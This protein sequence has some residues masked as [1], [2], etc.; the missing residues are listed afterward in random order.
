MSIDNR[1]RPPVPNEGRIEH[2]PSRPYENNPV[3]EQQDKTRGQ[4][5]D[6][7]KKK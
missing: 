2:K 3:R 5:G 1:G 7:L 6:A 4:V